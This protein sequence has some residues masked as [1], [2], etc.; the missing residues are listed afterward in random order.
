[1]K[2]AI[3]ISAKTF[4]LAES[5]AKRLKVSRSKIFAMGIE[6]LNEKLGEEFDRD[7]ITK[8][9]N[10]FYAEYQAEDEP[11]FRVIATRSLESNEW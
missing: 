7:E 11:E 4:D 9:L 10:G 2:I 3:S 6:K 1:M 5:L 8:K